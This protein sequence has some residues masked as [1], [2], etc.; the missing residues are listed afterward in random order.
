MSIDRNRSRH[1]MFDED[2]WDDPDVWPND[3]SEY[4]F[5][6]RAIEKIGCLQ[7]GDKWDEK[8][9]SI[10]RPPEDAAD[11]VW[12]KY[13]SDS[14]QQVEALK[15][16]VVSM[17]KSTA[18]KIAEECRNGN[19]ITGLRPLEGGECI[20]LDTSAWNTEYIYV[21]DR[22]YR[23]KMFPKRPFA[24]P[25]RKKY[26]AEQ[27]ACWIFVRRDSIAK[28]LALSVSERAA[29]LPHLSPY[30]VVMLE[31]A[32]KLNISR[33]NQPKKSQVVAEIT[34]AWKF[35]ADL[36]GEL[37]E[38]LCQTMATLVREPSSRLGRAKK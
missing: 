18:H 8:P 16:A 1:A 2:F 12:E 11:D 30:L 34:E 32:T 3:T 13:E 31:V 7:F 17:R 14:D 37:S 35:R 5:L 25:S 15:A 21:Q 26:L 10:E 28:L 29:Q 33:T 27:D 24:V 22:F 4:L 6:A 20:Q 19:F 23:C 9:P 38:K 36:H